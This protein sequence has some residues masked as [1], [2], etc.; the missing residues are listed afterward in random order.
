MFTMSC[1]RVSY[2]VRMLIF[3]RKL[4]SAEKIK[5][6]ETYPNIL[7]GS[8]SSDKDLARSL[9]KFVSCLQDIEDSKSYSPQKVNPN[10]LL[11]V[12]RDPGF[13]K[14]LYDSYNVSTMQICRYSKWP[15][16]VGDRKYQARSLAYIPHAVENMD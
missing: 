12:D 5:V 7:A 14:M 11:V 1:R 16:L 8:L 10:A 6:F 3:R 2:P 9:D 13:L 4:W 15:S